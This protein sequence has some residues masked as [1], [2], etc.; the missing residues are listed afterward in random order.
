MRLRRA[1]QPPTRSRHS[2]H[3]GRR[4]NNRSGKHTRYSVEGS[5]QRQHYRLAERPRQALSPRCHGTTCHIRDRFV[6][7]NR[8]SVTHDGPI[9]SDER[10]S[11]I[12]F[13]TFKPYG[14]PAGYLDGSERFKN[15]LAFGTGYQQERQ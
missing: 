9:T 7:S 3:N 8:R 1:S 13:C 4:A 2:R 11:E 10:Q 5:P 15:G 12:S 14:R 6:G